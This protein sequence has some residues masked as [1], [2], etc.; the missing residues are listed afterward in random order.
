MS[1]S[2]HARFGKL[3]DESDVDYYKVTLDSAAQFS[4]C[5]EHALPDDLSS[6]G[7]PGR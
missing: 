6:S 7:T 4:L 1:C 2:Q 5:L 3:S